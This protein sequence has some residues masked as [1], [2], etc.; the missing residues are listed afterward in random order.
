MKLV[1]ASDP[2]GIDLKEVV[3]AHLLAQGHTVMEV[4]PKTAQDE[5]YYVEAASALCRTL[6]EENCD[7]GILICGTGAGV[8]IVA[9]KHRG[10]YCVPCESA[11]T[12]FKSAQI[13]HANVISMGANVVGPGNACKIVDTWLESSFAMDGDE[14]RRAFLSGLLDQVRQLEAKNFG[15]K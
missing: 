5:I 1:I 12:A 4:G 9:N 3:K 8:S 10:I 11:F 6:L 7:R 14:T 15:G 13:N 2:F